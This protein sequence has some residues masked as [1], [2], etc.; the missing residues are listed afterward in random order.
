MRRFKTTLDT[1]KGVIHASRQDEGKV[2]SVMKSAYSMVQSL[3]R[4]NRE[5]NV[6]GALKEADIGFLKSFWNITDNQ[7]ISVST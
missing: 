5:R 6:E 1:V 4:E 2:F 3:V 7:M